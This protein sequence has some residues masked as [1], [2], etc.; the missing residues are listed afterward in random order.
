M[1]IIRIIMIIIHK[2][3]VNDIQGPNLVNGLGTHSYNSHIANEG[4][5]FHT[6]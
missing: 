3:K 4:T 2:I 5:E 6:I 1:L